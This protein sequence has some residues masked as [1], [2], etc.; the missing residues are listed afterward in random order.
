MPDRI[1]SRDR[2]LP[3]DLGVGMKG[4]LLSGGMD[5]IA[6]AWWLRP[7]QAITVDYGQLA[8]IAETRTSRQVCEELGIGH[9]VIEARCPELGSGDM[10]GDAPHQLAPVPEWWPFRNQLLAT[11]AGMKAVQ[12]GVTELIF[13]AVRGDG[14]HADGLPRFFE[15]LDRLMSGQEG[16]LNV[17][18]PAIGMSTEELIV[19]SK[20][21]RSVLAWAHS[22]H[23]G[24]LACGDCRGC[25]K[26]AEVIANVYG[27]L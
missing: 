23:R 17:T 3:F 16:G 19:K 1:G 26:N 2:H 5:S 15:D 10:A 14:S 9:T 27:D 6:L 4:L 20:V 8:A 7:E 21:P 25:Y 12:L 18:A 24:D 22:C 13:G 11:L